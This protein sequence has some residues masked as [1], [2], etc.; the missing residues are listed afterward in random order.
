MLISAT[1]VV[2]SSSSAKT[3]M[4]YIRSYMSKN[5]CELGALIPVVRVPR[6]EAQKYAQAPH[7]ADSY[8][9]HHW[10]HTWLGWD[11]NKVDMADQVELP[12]AVEVKPG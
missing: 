1:T 4:M 10:V 9:V 7:G 11:Q 6:L 12:A 5:T 2:L 3:A 8:T